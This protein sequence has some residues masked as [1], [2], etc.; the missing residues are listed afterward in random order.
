MWFSMV[1]ALTDYEYASSHWSKCCGQRKLA[2]QIARLA[3]I[4]VKLYIEVS[5]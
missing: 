1:C 2:N 4:V 5:V 3:A